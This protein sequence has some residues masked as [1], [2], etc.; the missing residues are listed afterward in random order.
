LWEAEPVPA[1]ALD[2]G[3]VFAYVEPKAHT[4][5]L[6]W[7]GLLVSALLGGL[8]SGPEAISLASVP[9]DSPD[10]VA[11]AQVFRAFA[12]IVTEGESAMEA[13]RDLLTQPDCKLTPD[14]KWAWFARIDPAREWLATN[15]RPDLSPL[16]DRFTSFLANCLT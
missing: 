3:F 11:N 12:V 2:A 4:A 13:A 5:Q 14:Q 8:I 9:G 6:L 1:G 15:G 16:L 7:D 10:S